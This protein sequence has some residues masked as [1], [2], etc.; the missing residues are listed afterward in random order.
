MNFSEF[1]INF[2]DFMELKIKFYNLKSN[3]QII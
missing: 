3:F 2:K 1:L